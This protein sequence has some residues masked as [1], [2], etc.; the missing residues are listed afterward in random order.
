[1]LTKQT[2]SH[3]IGTKDLVP[4]YPSMETLYHQN[5]PF[6]SSFDAYTALRDTPERGKPLTFKTCLYEKY[7]IVFHYRTL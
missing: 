1:M 2:E 7:G 6:V 4:S 5:D 3:E